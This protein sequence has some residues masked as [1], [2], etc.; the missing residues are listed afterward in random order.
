[1][2]HALLDSK[3]IAVA[4]QMSL[5]RELVQFV[6]NNYERAY[7]V[8]V[9]H[10]DFPTYSKSYAGFDSYLLGLENCGTWGGVLEITYVCMFYRIRIILVA[11][12]ISDGISGSAP[13][14]QATDGVDLME[15]TEEA[16]LPQNAVL[17]HVY[18]HQEA[19][20]L[21]PT[22]NA[23]I[24]DLDHFVYLTPE[25]PQ[26]PICTE[27][28]QSSS[29]NI[30]SEWKKILDG[31]KRKN[32]Q[33]G[34][35]S[36]MV[37]TK[38]KKREWDTKMCDREMISYFDPLGK[39][40]HCRACSTPQK[41]KKISA[42]NP[43]QNYRWN[44]HCK[45]K[46]HGD[47][48]SIFVSQPK[49]SK[50]WPLMEKTNLMNHVASSFS[51]SALAHAPARF[52]ALFRKKCKGLHPGHE[53]LS[54]MQKY[55]RYDD[56]H[57]L[58]V[59]ENNGLETRAHHYECT[60]KPSSEYKK[61]K[62]IRSCDSCQSAHRE[63]KF[64]KR[65][66][67][68]SK[69][70]IVLD[71]LSM[72]QI[73]DDQVTILKNFSKYES[74]PVPAKAKLMLQTK[75]YVS[76]AQWFEKHGRELALILP[77]AT[78]NLNASTPSYVGIVSAD[79]V[80]SNFVSAYTS[81]ES[82]QQNMLLNALIQSYTC[83]MN[84]R[85]N[86]P[87]ASTLMDLCQVI[88]YKSA[89][90][91]AFLRENM[92]L[93]SVRHLVCED[94]K[95]YDDKECILSIGDDDI[96]NRL[97]RWSNICIS[98][99]LPS[100]ELKVVVVSLMYDATKVQKMYS[101][102]PTNKIG[103]GK[104][105]P[106][107]MELI[108]DA[109]QLLKSQPE[110]SELA[111]EVKCVMLAGQNVPGFQSPCQLLAA[112]TQGSNEICDA[113]TEDIVTLVENHPRFHLLNISSDG[114]ASER[115]LVKNQTIQYMEGT[116]N[117]VG[118]M[119]PN[120]WGKAGRSQ[121]ILGSQIKTIGGIFI[122][123]GLLLLAK[124][125]KEVCIVSDYSSDTKVL[126][127]ASTATFDRLEQL[128]NEDDEHVGALG[129]T[130]LFL[131]LF[132]NA[133]NSDTMPKKRRLYGIW[134]SFLWFTSMEGIHSITLTNLANCV[135]GLI[136][137]VLR[138]DVRSLRLVTTE[139]LEHYFGHI[140]TWNSEFNTLDFTRFTK[141]LDKMMDA[142]FRSGL[143]S[144]RGQSKGY[145]SGFDGFQQT[146]LKMLLARDGDSN[147]ELPHQFSVEV[148]Y[149]GVPAVFQ[150]Q[151]EVLTI[152]NAASDDM[153]HL[154][155][156]TDIFE[157]R[158]RHSPFNRRFANTGELL[159]AYK[160]YSPAQ[161]VEPAS[162]NLTEA[163]DQYMMNVIG[164]SIAEVNELQDETK[165]DEDRIIDKICTSMEQMQVEDYD[166][167]GLSKYFYRHD[168]KSMK[169]LFVAMKN[170]ISGQDSTNVPES[171]DNV[172]R[173]SLFQ[174]WINKDIPPT[175]HGDLHRGVIFSMDGKHYRAIT[176]FQ[177]SY[178]KWRMI[179]T[180]Q[181]FAKA[182]CFAEEVEVNDRIGCVTDKKQYRRIMG[183]EIGSIIGQV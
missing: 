41:T 69:V 96:M 79:S 166:V 144:G 137:L 132:L 162:D 153:V 77:G 100:D 7:D 43:F 84:G 123:P 125:P 169:D 175:E 76:Y 177:K 61:S 80:L 90:A 182:C 105:F 23:G 149:E 113:Y 44:E 179:E 174:R 11:Y 156:R 8:F 40:L 56:L 35:T 94:N 39:Y 136:W 70:K 29:S 78:V 109:S 26:E 46:S 122:D 83:K 17:V 73:T 24:H 12:M 178:N 52:S 121:L 147:P 74:D 22:N 138:K 25:Q 5:R 1:M 85:M 183:N 19:K 118:L 36:I 165:E 158:P 114:L 111:H 168:I 53:L 145:L 59:T 135:F 107:Q 170:H 157:T 102:C 37:P 38:R 48:V 130:L 171:R 143:T 110:D 45:T 160:N 63:N 115:R 33:E 49:I 13:F 126:Q 57:I 15:L 72:P 50:S 106:N 167:Y 155:G 141:K 4:D 14:M 32:S 120:H 58:F 93:P 117:T 92:F 104:K 133:V 140:R 28:Q 108:T 97:D 148:N 161:I 172:K 159:F 131:R 89:S 27:E 18:H 21:S 98:N 62:L 82:N 150:L 68:M 180:T 103:L 65:M 55:G 86:A 54:L 64:Y 176:C 134:Y 112:R 71:I 119:D 129:L 2:L 101:V 34:T 60:G 127:L 9:T 51:T 30:T 3:Q 95:M 81:C 31:G 128:E 146:V 47:K 87:Y 6:N 124:V 20:P 10:G 116:S 142:I 173:K 152:I 154:F 163:N 139:C 164:R 66:M 181:C 99:M 42:K 16:P 151:A 75:N 91:Y 67:F 88:R